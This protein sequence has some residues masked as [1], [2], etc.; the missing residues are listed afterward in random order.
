[1][2][3]LNE[4]LVTPIT[5]KDLPEL[6]LLQRE[7]VDEEGDLARMKQLFPVI[8]GDSNY[9]LLCARKNGKFVGSLAGIV[10]HDLF[11]KCI[12]FMV[13]ENM[14]VGKE[15][16]RQGIGTILMAEIESIAQKKGC[17]YITLVSSINRPEA[18]KFYHCCGYESE[19]YRG[20]KK[21][22]TGNQSF[23]PS[24]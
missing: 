18:H 3:T 22:M 7:L 16:R 1:M 20:F 13:V 12:P 21:M 8:L 5:E 2:N 17:R 14:V 10:C 19:P 15:Y 6:A 4:I 11:G 23:Q 24:S 9:H